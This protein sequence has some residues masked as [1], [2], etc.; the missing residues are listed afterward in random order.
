MNR[1]L[2]MIRYIFIVSIRS[3]LEMNMTVV[4]R[5]ILSVTIDYFV[6]RIVQLQGVSLVMRVHSLK[7]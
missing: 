3:L 1:Y 4:N 6:T 5:A 7:E 2:K